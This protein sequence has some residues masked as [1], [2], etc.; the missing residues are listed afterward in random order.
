MYFDFVIK[1]DYS[2]F[3][4]GGRFQTRLFSYLVEVLNHSI[5]N[6]FLEKFR[7]RNHGGAFYDN[8]TP[9][10]KLEQLSASNLRPRSSDILQGHQKLVDKLLVTDVRDEMCW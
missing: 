2:I 10:Y 5:F 9:L 4:A 1:L 6:W 8:C 3:I 7:W